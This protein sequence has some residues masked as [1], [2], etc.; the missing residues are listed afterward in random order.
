MLPVLSLLSSR[1]S[2]KTL[3]EANNNYNDNNKID[4]VEYFA[5]LI[6]FKTFE[7]SNTGRLKCVFIMIILNWFSG[8]WLIW[9]GILFIFQS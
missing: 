6:Q 4:P 5:W 1:K 8:I 2:T 7:A 9:L 3:P